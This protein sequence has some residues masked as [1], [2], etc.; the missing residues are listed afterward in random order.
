MA[1]PQ[2]SAPTET[3]FATSGTSHPASMPAV[4]NP[5]EKLVV[6]ISLHYIAFNSPATIT[7]P[8]G[9]RVA[10]NA[11]HTVA[12]NVIEVGCYER[13]ADGTE[14]GTTVDFVT[15][16]TDPNSNGAA[17][18]YSITGAR[19]GAAAIEVGVENNG[20]SANPDP[21]SVSPSWGVEDTLW[22]ALTGA[23]DDDAT[24]TSYPANYT[25]GVSTISGAPANQKSSICVARRE[26][27]AASDNPGT[28]TLSEAEL[29]IAQTVAIR[30]A[31][32][33]TGNPWYHYRQ[34]GFM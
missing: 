27:A 25:N 3:S 30:P 18:C 1:F 24:A 20:A 2:T 26:L 15:S 14:G 23:A 8:D 31:A 9:W 32:P 7:K 17:Q 22:F 33:A 29:W 10:W 16:G 4:V 6:F 21:P 11:R 5:G 34:Q 12:S 13:D 19:T 28:F